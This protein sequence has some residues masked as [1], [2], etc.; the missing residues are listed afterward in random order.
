M[1]SKLPVCAAM[2]LMCSYAAAG[3][4]AIGTASARGD[5]RIDGYA[6]KGNATLFDGTVVETDQA[7]A[8]LRLGQGVEIKLASAS[9]GTL[10]RD[11]MVLEQG[12]SEF[13]SSNSFSLEAKGLRVTPDQ[14][15]SRAVVSM[16]G[17]TTIE[18]AALAGG[19]QIAND[20]G[21]LLAHLSTGRAMSFAMQTQT[22]GGGSITVEGQLYKEDGHYYIMQSL[23]NTIY[24]LKGRGF[25]W[26]EGQEVTITGTT[27]PR[28]T[29]TGGA[30]AVIDVTGMTKEKI[31]GQGIANG[32]SW[33]IVGSIAAAGAVIGW[34]INDVTQP[35]APA[36]R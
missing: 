34:A 19:F 28:A 20:R 1:I 9:R 11:R 18:V 13:A 4:N 7:T 3:S 25:F 27:D 32:P 16:T 30:K 31:S 17:L 24:L 15:S 33:V 23:S 8:A 5:M 14:P 12:E 10:Y 21:L 22:G 35:S 6:V 36:S 2:F 29:P 26:S